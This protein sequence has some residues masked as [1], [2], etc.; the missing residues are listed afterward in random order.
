M[1]EAVAALDRLGHGAEDVVDGYKGAFGRVGGRCGDIWGSSE[2]TG[3]RLGGEKVEGG[4]GVVDG[5]A[6]GQ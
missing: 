4:K 6:K 3:S 2:Q 1:C 5:S